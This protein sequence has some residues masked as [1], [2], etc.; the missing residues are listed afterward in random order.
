MKIDEDQDLSTVFLSFRTKRLLQYFAKKPWSLYLFP[1]LHFLEK[2]VAE[3]HQLYTERMLEKMKERERE[4]NE[5]DRCEDGPVPV[6]TEGKNKDKD[7]DDTV[8]VW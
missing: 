4:N 8:S 5:K 7:I 1:L 6:C 2:S 3:Q